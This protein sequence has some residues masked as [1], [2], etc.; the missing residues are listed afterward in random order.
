MAQVLVFATLDD[1]LPVLAAVEDRA[2]LTYSLEGQFPSDSVIQYGSGAEV[3]GLGQARAESYIA[4]L[5]LLVGSR[6]LEI[7]TREIPREDGTTVF[8]VD[9][10][11]NPDTIVFMPGGTWGEGTLI[12]GVVASASDSGASEALLRRF[13]TV[14]RR[15]FSQVGAYWVGKQ[16]RELLRSGWRLTGSVGS[17]R[18]YDLRDR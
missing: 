1:W 8:A 14:V 12:S 7:L 4:G 15:E 9:Q 11:V 13:R 16:A 5:S 18:E 3:P 10:L 6:G 2:P 17:P